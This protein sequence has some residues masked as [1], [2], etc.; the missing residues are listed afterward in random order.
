MPN[1]KLSSIKTLNQLDNALIQIEAKGPTFGILEGRKFEIDGKKLSLND[2]YKKY[3]E[4]LT[5]SNLDNP[6]VAKKA[7]QILER[8][9]HINELTIKG[10]NS[11]KQSLLNLIRKITKSNHKRELLIIKAQKTL[12]QHPIASTEKPTNTQTP[13][14][15]KKESDEKKPVKTPFEKLETGSRSKTKVKDAGTTVDH[16]SAF[17]I[18]PSEEAANKVEIKTSSSTQPISKTEATNQKRVIEERKQKLSNF[19][20]EELQ[21]HPN[22]NS[23]ALIDK[24]RY[25][26]LMDEI[27]QTFS[28][29]EKKIP[30]QLQNN[31]AKEVTAEMEKREEIVVYQV[32]TGGHQGTFSNYLLLGIGKKFPKA[33]GEEPAAEKQPGQNSQAIQTIGMAPD[34]LSP[35]QK[36]MYTYIANKSM[37]MKKTNQAEYTLEFAEV[38]TKTGMPGVIKVVEEGLYKVLDRLVSE[39]IIYA[40]AEARAGMRCPIL[41][42][43]ETI[44]NY[45]GV[46]IYTKDHPANKAPLSDKQGA[47]PISSLPSLEATKAKADQVEA[48][49]VETKLQFISDFEEGVTELDIRHNV[50]TFNVL[51]NRWGQRVIK[52]TWTR[53]ELK[54]LLGTTTMDEFLDRLQL[55]QEDIP[56]VALTYYFICIQEALENKDLGMKNP[57]MLI[58]NKFIGDFAILAHGEDRFPGRTAKDKWT[59][60]ELSMYFACKK[61]TLIQ[62][63]KEHNIQPI[64]GF[65]LSQDITVDFLESLSELLQNV[66]SPQKNSIR[67][68]GIGRI[69]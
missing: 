64:K 3:N 29:E 18:S 7:H 57:Y 65:Y 67:F 54:N 37:S 16:K 1:V 8:L 46:P 63:L 10:M 32:G 60:E 41:L 24:T 5:D 66:T 48:K 26:N 9:S 61:E 43:P 44:K 21:N 36:Q 11:Y 38:G 55:I 12:K 45:P 62:K 56:T 34:D 27:E 30:G 69:Q 58:K 59:L 20:L 50:D 14:P 2:L 6:Q 22:K 31:L 23:M 15:Q 33:Q 17:Q 47:A 52:S 13:S 42:T 35:N 68:A 19:I 28:S 51:L 4:I 40:W 53:T 49:T 25:Q 39:G